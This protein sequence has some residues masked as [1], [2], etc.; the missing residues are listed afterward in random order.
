MKIREAIQKIDSYLNTIPMAQRFLWNSRNTIRHRRISYL[1]KE[2]KKF[3]NCHVGKRCFILGNGPSL[4]QVDFSTLKNEIVFTVNQLP[5]HPDF[6]K[7]HTNYHFFSDPDFYTENDSPEGEEFLHVIKSV[8]TSDN[9]PQVFYKLEGYNFVRRHH[10]DQ[11]LNI[12]YYDNRMVNLT[13]NPQSFIDFTHQVP[14]VLSVV[15]FAIEMAVYMGFKEIYLL[16]CDCS[17]FISTAQMRLQLNEDSLYGFELSLNEKTRLTKR[18][19]VISMKQD[20][21]Q[22]VA[23]FEGYEYLQRYC[24][25]NKRFLYNATEG[26]LLENLPRVH[27]CDILAK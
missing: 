24:N 15:Q 11:I 26:G 5:R 23:I 17:G 8:K 9:T 16:G 4:K 21:I 1:L 2:N 18:S 12:A 22:Y 13:R 14:E 7:L 6:P 19:S 3:Y 20:L 10:L 25:R 27:L